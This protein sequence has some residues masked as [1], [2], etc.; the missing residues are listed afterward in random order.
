MFSTNGRLKWV[1]Q[2]ISMFIFN[3]AMGI[4]G[5]QQFSEQEPQYMQAKIR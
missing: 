1:T 5:L 2:L 4:V 3:M